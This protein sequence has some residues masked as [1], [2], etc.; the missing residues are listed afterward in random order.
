MKAIW[1]HIGFI[2][3]DLWDKSNILSRCGIDYRVSVGVR[4]KKAAGVRAPSTMLPQMT[5][6]EDT[7]VARL[8]SDAP[9]PAQSGFN[10][11][12]RLA[13]RLDDTTVRQATEVD[14]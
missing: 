5:A 9:T 1:G 11:R 14:L 7:S 10:A 12:D 6:H 13:G 8:D 3:G 4:P 2:I